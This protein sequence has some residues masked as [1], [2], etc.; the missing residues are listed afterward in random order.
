MTTIEEVVTHFAGDVDKFDVPIEGT[1]DQGASGDFARKHFRRWANKAHA[2]EAW[3][4]GNRDYP[5][6]ASGRCLKESEQVFEKPKAVWLQGTPWTFIAD[7]IA[8]H[9]RGPLMLHLKLSPLTIA[10][11]NEGMLKT[12]HENIYEGKVS[13][14]L[15]EMAIPFHPNLI[16]HSVVPF[17]IWD[18]VL[19]DA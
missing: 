9:W 6:W 14:L 16:Y 7:R 11:I 17:A 13:W 10:A 19:R 4:H 3:S 5:R 8:P 2:Q 12:S 15:K 18:V 1:G